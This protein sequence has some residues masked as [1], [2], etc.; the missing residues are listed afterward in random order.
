M[1]QFRNI[2]IVRVAKGGPGWAAL[3][4]RAVAF[5]KRGTIM[6]QEIEGPAWIPAFLAALAETGNVGRAIEAAGMFT[7]R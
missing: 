4:R 7:S 6:T 5:W 2:A 3:F 1:A